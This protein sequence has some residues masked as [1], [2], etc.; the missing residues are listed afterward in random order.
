V[1]SVNLG[2]I[3]YKRLHIEGSTLR[4]RSLEYQADLV[5]RYIL[6]RLIINFASRLVLP[7]SNWIFS[8]R[9]QDKMV[10]DPFAL[11]LIR[12]ATRWNLI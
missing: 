11:I 8:Q 4:S 2:L 12:Y 10:T 9:S 1:D 7:G 6:E 3:L 5:E